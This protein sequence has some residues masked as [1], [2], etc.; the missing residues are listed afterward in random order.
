MDI[1]SDAEKTYSALRDVLQQYADMLTE[2]R[3]DATETKAVTVIISGNR[4]KE[5][6]A[7]EPLRYAGMDGRLAD[8]AGT[9]AKHF[10]PLIS[11]NWGL[12]FK[13]RGSGDLPEEERQ[14]LKQYVS[15]AHE[16]GRRIRFW[17]APDN[18]ASWR[19]LRAAG[20]DL[21]NTDN[22]AGL[23][24]FLLE[25]RVKVG[26]GNPRCSPIPAWMANIPHVRR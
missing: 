2:F 17:A 6:M 19:E 22:L 11:D 18:P 13:W 20:V 21:I 8:L 25:A 4:P 16:Q 14:K 7:A 5:M 23:E 12:V 24:A 3:P 1:K 10:I 15:Q 9:D 26:P